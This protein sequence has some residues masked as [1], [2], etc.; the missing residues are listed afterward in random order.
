LGALRL[1]CLMGATSLS[2]YLRHHASIHDPEA[3][4]N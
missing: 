2:L 4:R 3:I 1:G